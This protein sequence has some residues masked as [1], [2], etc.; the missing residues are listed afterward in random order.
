M[1]DIVMGGG[2]GKSGGWRGL[3]WMALVFLL[4]ALLQA[5]WL[6]TD[7]R[8]LV[9]ERHY[10][11]SARIAHAWLDSPVGR[12]Y[13]DHG[14]IS[15]YPP[16]V[17]YYTAP[18]L[19]LLGICADSAVLSLLPFAWLLMWSAWRIARRF[20]TE[21][22]AAAAGVMALALHHF[23][24]VEPDYPAHAFMKEYLL[25]LPLSAM[26]ALC[27]H[28]ALRVL[29][30]P[31][32]RFQ[33][34]LGIAA[35]CGALTKVSLPV[36]GLIGV[37]VLL[38]AGYRDARAWR[39]MI[40]PA[41]IAAA[42]ALPWYALHAPDLALALA[43]QEFNPEWARACGMPEVFSMAGL[44]CWGPALLRVFSAPLAVLAA[45]A[46]AVALVKRPGGWRLA[47][48]GCLL[49]MLALS[50]FPG[51]SE[52]L[53][54]PALIF[55]CLG[56]ALAAGAAPAGAARSLVCGLIIGAGCFRMLYMN[57]A[58]PALLALEPPAVRAEIPPLA[59]DW[60][61][62]A[63]MDDVMRERTPNRL[64]RLAVAP[65]LGH[66]RNASFMQAAIRESV[67]MNRDSE[68]ML[69]G[70]QWQRELELAEFVVVKTGAQ[71]PARFTPHSRDV[72]LQ[73]AANPRARLV[74]EYP[75]PDGE[76][77][78]LFKQDLVFTSWSAATSAPPGKCLVNFD[79]KVILSDYELR[80]AG[81]ELLLECRWWSI[82]EF[83]KEYRL[84]V[85]VRKG[86]QNLVSMTFQPGEGLYPVLDWNDDC[87]LV[88]TVRIPLPPDA[89]DGPFDVWI[90]WHRR[91]RRL[92][93]KN[94]IFT[95][96]LN[97]VCIG[98]SDAARTG[99]LG[100]QSLD[101]PMER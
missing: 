88:E 24:V 7:R 21:G 32:R 86:M 50:V 98:K 79:N 78:R 43:R 48:F 22:P 38:L 40:A 36:Y 45:A 89:R 69:R 13:P 87:G 35:G 96:M 15:P 26:A 47:I 61:V 2:P 57:G 41:L 80:R 85:Q 1:T 44:A 54:A 17:V 53:L 77:A 30:D 81:A 23:V 65:F 31:R 42:I 64:P 60:S 72:E 90:G 71:G 100:V 76:K 49:S 8:A 5:V 82:D 4:F 39:R 20:T 28:L 62:R 74:S 66:F 18:W 56:I 12:E 27:L 67:R 9:V 33:A 73:V 95:V 37:C 11:A 75:L 14:R 101:P 19:I 3:G 59:D 93:I 25:D 52:R 34:A 83:E 29:E 63:I 68:W 51:K 58:A 94:S 6:R 55:A 16:L 10:F 46:L 99:T 70:P 92:P 97:S 91:G 84:F